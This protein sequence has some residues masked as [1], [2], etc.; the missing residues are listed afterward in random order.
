MSRLEGNSNEE[1][2]QRCELLRQEALRLQNARSLV[3]CRECKTMHRAAS[4]PRCQAFREG[5]P[6]THEELA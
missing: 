3:L 2:D 4:C 6:W 5:R 1:I